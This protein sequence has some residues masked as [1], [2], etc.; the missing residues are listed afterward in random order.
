MIKKIALVVLLIIFFLPL[1]TVGPSLTGLSLYEGQSVA[2]FPLKVMTLNL[3]HGRKEGFHQA[4]QSQQTIQSHLNEV[5]QVLKREQAQI[6]AFQEADGPSLWSGNFDH[7]QYLAE[8]ANYHYFGRGEHVK[9]LGLSYGTALLSLQPLKQLYSLT[10][11]PSLPL[12]AKGFVV[13]SLQGES[14]PIDVVSVHLDFARPFVRRR[15]MET[16]SHFLKFR[17]RSLIIMG[18]FNCEWPE[19]QSLIGKLDVHPYQSEAT[20]LNTFPTSRRSNRI[21]WILIS[22]D[23][24]FLTY[25][26]LGDIL[27]DHF[28]VIA[29]LRVK[30]KTHRF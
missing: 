25:Q 16:M 30:P 24:E 2:S 4:F 20:H 21:D 23:L 27:S 5:V 11:F 18:D 9:G 6:V 8:Q 29:S 7:L 13:G 10:F 19:L 17:E 15:Q 22:A 3:A 28:G 26:V 14:G 12:P 1:L